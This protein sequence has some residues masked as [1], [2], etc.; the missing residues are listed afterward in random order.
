MGKPGD[1]IIQG[2]ATL[3]QTERDSVPRTV[4]PSCGLLYFGRFPT[5]L[6]NP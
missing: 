3:W 5:P 2:R 6:V 1:F 4:W